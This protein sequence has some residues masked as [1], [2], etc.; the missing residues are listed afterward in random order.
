MIIPVD[1]RPDPSLQNT[2]YMIKSF[3]NETIFN[4]I[5]TDRDLE[6]CTFTEENVENTYRPKI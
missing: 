1:S 6:Q 5:E 2:G 4:D 3:N